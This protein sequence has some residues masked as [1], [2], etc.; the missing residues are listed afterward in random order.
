MTGQ[1]TDT[2]LCSSEGKST[3]W[4]PSLLLQRCRL[5]REGKCVLQ[6]RFNRALT[7]QAEPTGAM[8]G[9]GQ[10]AQAL[11]CHPQRSGAPYLLYLPARTQNVVLLLV[12]KT[13]G[14]WL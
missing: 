5:Y 13:Q 2:D 4:K 12:G 8:S 3:R 9:V 1:V 11:R 14:V 10:T 7:E 6:T